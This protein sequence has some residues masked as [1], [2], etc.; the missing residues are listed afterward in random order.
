[1]IPTMQLGQLGIASR[2]G[3]SSGDPY[4]A[5]VTSLLHFDG[6]DASTTF[7]DQIGITWSANDNAQIDTA[8]SKFGGASGLFD[9][10]ND[11]ITTSSVQS[12]HDFGS[13][14]FTIEAQVRTTS[15]PGAGTY[16][17]ISSRDDTT[18]SSN[19]GW[20]FLLNGDDSGRLRFVTR[21]GTTAYAVAHTTT[22]SLNTW[23]HVAAVRDGGTLRLYV[24]GVQVASTSITGTVNDANVAT[25][26]G[27]GNNGGGSLGSWNG[28]ID[29]HRITKGVCRY[30]SGTT[31]TPQ[32]AAFPNF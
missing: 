25:R 15:T 14:D 11:R 2:S 17:V 1:M 10:T 18:A 23:Y 28:W 5:S 13:G 4:F 8:Q 26:I 29:E 24:D 7:T 31:F 19:R 21:V 3:T 22:L 32:T 12:G 9:G 27:D 16:R 20:L 30:P 6:A